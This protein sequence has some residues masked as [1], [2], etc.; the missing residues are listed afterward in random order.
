MVVACPPSPAGSVSSTS[1][2]DDSSQSSDV[3][4]WDSQVQT[5]HPPIF[6]PFSAL[7]KDGLDVASVERNIGLFKGFGSS[8]T[9]SVA[10]LFASLMSKPR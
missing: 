9:E 8:N 4:A 5:R 3:S 6:P 10:E 2:D 1:D 7:L